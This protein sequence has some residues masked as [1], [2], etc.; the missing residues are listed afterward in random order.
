MLSGA[1][2]SQISERYG[3]QE[4]YSNQITKRWFQNSRKEARRS[5]SSDPDLGNN[6]PEMASLY[7]N[8]KKHL[9]R[10]NEIIDQEK[11]KIHS[12]ID[13]NKDLS[14]YTVKNKPDDDNSEERKVKTKF[15]KPAL[16]SIK[17]P[18]DFSDINKMLLFYKPELQEQ[19]G[20][21]SGMQVQP[22][23]NTNVPTLQDMHM[24][25][26]VI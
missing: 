17:N 6:I 5:N 22:S 13:D 12:T 7:P 16:L 19:D 4:Y 2:L 1:K 24:G 26:H 21:Q 20:M 8:N 25:T 10:N 14:I 3:V 11:S 18:E 15:D 23:P 9:I